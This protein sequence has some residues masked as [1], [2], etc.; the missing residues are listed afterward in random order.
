MQVFTHPPCQDHRMTTT[1]TLQHAI[2]WFEIPVRDMDRAQAFYEALLQ[3]PLR[4]E[5]MGPQTLA[6]LPYT[7]PGTGG[8]LIAGEHIPA[9]SALGTLVY[10]NVNPVLDAALARAVAAGAQV[11]VPRV[12]LPDGMGSFVQVLDSE[13]NRIGLHAAA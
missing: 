13:G 5:A 3:A 10:L 1:H 11:L 6:V 7:E 9:P 8:A 12:D 2:N 4:R